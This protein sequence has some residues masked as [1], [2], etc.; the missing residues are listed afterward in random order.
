MTHIKKEEIKQYIKKKRMRR[1]YV[2]GAMSA[3]NIL[4]VLGNISEGIKFGA[5]LLERGYASFVPHFDVFF[6]LQQGRDYNIPMKYYYDYTMEWLKV[7]EAVVVVPD[8]EN[9]V[10]TKNEIQMAIKLGL[11]V[12]YSIEEL[13]R[14]LSKE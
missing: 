14:G 6:R 4:D 9:S 3:D 10:G 11:P 7:S 13:E 5:K 1:I 12:F 8:W 2:A